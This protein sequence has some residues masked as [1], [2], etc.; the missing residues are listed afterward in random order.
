MSD[1][2]FG[3]VKKFNGEK[4]F[5]FLIVV[6]A[7]GKPTGEEIFFHIS[8]E[9]SVTVVNDDLIFNRVKHSKDDTLRKPCDDDQ[10]IFVRG[11][12]RND[13]PAAIQW[14]YADN[15]DKALTLLSAQTPVYR[16]SV[17]MSFMGELATE[18]ELGE[19]ASIE[20]LTEAHPILHFKGE[21][22]DTL[23]SYDL[24]GVEVYYS[25]ETMDSS[26]QWQTCADPRPEPDI[27]KVQL[28]SVG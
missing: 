20:E 3:I 6:D 28:A 2:S 27:T 14:F 5:G 15:Y 18:R 25:F 9:Q 7:N 1:Y 12:G 10:I 22:C 19:Y 23:A 24:N 4:A 26:G 11:M 16:V 13:R 21:F 8:G 17:V